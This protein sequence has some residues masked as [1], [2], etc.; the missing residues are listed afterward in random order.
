[1]NQAYTLGN[2]SELRLL[3]GYS[4]PPRAGRITAV[5]PASY[6]VEIADSDAAAVAAWPLNGAVYAEGNVVYVLQAENAPDSGVIVG[7]KGAL[8]ALGI[9]TASPQAALDVRG[10]MYSTG[11][12]GWKH[13]KAN[14]AH[15]TPAAIAK[16][17]LSG[18]TASAVLVS[19][20]AGGTGIL[21]TKLFSVTTAWSTEVVTDLGGALF[22]F[23]GLVLT[24]AMNTATRECTLTLTQTNSAALP[25]N[26]HISIQPLATS[27]TATMTFTGL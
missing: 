27:G 8:T 23:S 4:G 16:Y 5:N 10:P 7:R 19:I 13:S 18:S 6:T 25:A 21:A 3:L 12:L 11:P 26:I 24:A 14:V 1:M 22:G 9:G 17:T 15:N 20:V 2:D